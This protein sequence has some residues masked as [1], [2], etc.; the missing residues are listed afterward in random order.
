MKKMFAAA[1]MALAMLGVSTPSHAHGDI[2]PV[3]GGQVTETHE[4]W[5][6][7]FVVVDG[8]VHAWVRDHEDKPVTATGKAALLIHGKKIDTPLKADGDMLT[9]DASVTA[10]DKITAVLSLSVGGKPISA[11]F[12]K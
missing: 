12:S 5:R 8:G 11:R 1:A 4:G 7:E 2:K 3:H 9:G 10:S 6:V